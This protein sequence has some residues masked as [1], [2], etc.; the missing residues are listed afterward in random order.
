MSLDDVDFKIL[1]LLQE[2]ARTPFSRIARQVGISE[3]TVHMR[4]KKLK[5]LGALRGFQA[6]VNPLS[7]G[8]GFTAITLVKADPAKHSEILER[9]KSM[10]DIYE[11]YDVTGEYDAV[12]KLRSES[13]EGL[14]SII[15]S[16][17]QIAGVSATLTMVVLKTVKEEYRIRF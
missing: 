15:D 4:V 11:V 14:A 13:K 10:P 12:V 1:R 9:L 8:K 2:D 3:G 16:I 5:K 6:L 17:G 7:V